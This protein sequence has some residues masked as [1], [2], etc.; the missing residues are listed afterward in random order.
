MFDD[1]RDAGRRLATALERFRKDRPLVLALP[2]GGVPVGFEV[3][4]A[5]G[6]RLDVLIVRKIGAPF[7]P[8][9]GVGAVGEGG[10]TV[11][12]RPLMMRAG[13]DEAR[14]Q[15]II[16]AETAE[17]RRR[18]DLYRAG[19]PMLD[20][21]DRT[22]IVV[23]DGL[24]TGFTARAAVDAVRSMGAATVVVAVPVGAPDTVAA[25]EELADHVVCL[26]TPRFFMAVGEFYRDFR[27]TSDQEVVALLAAS[28][29]A[30]EPDA[31]DVTRIE[32]AI[33]AGPVELPGDLTVPAA[34]TGIVIFAHGSG[35]SRLSPRNAAVAGH[36]NDRGMAT[37]MFD[38]LTDREAGDRANVFDVPLLGG[39]LVA[40]TRWV[41]AAPE[42][43]H[44]PYAYF[45]ASTGAA[46]ALW[47]A[48][49][50]APAAV[51]SRGG[52][53]DLA[54]AR[55]PQVRAPTLLIVGELDDVVIDLN[56]RAEKELQCPARLVVVPQAG[57]LFEEPGALEQ[58]AELASDWFR[59]YLAASPAG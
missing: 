33:S 1:R 8:E 15:P 10:V 47:A 36:L 39:R 7:Q 46:A 54:L 44:L 57:H 59:R 43:G 40:A 42:I 12:N 38:L 32:V 28:A 45:G 2:R 34:A 17:V 21:R 3:A 55:L 19:R 27:Q 58:V 29:P 50:L 13:V 5:L 52:R 49:E 18:V 11:L 48:S 53:P 23:D 41:Q 4:V 16:A 35:S 25:L 51:V 30:A 9:L 31:G 20:P 6:A 56:R 24:A 26:N 22:V 37:L 14:L